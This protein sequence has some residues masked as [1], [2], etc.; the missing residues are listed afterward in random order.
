MNEESRS[1]EFLNKVIDNAV[2]G[3]EA[4]KMLFE[5]IEDDKMAS[6]LKR[7]Y[8]CYGEHTKRAVQAL[9][10]EGLEPEKQSK[11]AK[12][13]LW[14]GIQLNTLTERSND[15]IAEIMIQGSIMGVIDLSRLLKEYSEIPDGYR[16]CAVDLIKFEEDSIQKLKA[17]LG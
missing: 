3:A 12:L 17:F 7:E 8:E 2:M 1:V 15:K 9:G 5:K 14:S 13:G 10:S 16:E 6:E 4:V 11:M